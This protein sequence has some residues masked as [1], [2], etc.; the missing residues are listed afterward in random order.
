MKARVIARDQS[1][2]KV[3]PIAHKGIPKYTSGVVGDPTSAEMGAALTMGG[4]AG[5]SFPTRLPNESNPNKGGKQGMSCL[6]RSTASCLL[7]VML[8][9]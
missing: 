8:K 7:Q 9:K 3:L 6:R 1:H 2:L 4:V 5:L